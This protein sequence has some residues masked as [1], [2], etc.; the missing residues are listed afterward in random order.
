MLSPALRTVKTHYS[1]F[2]KHIM[3]LLQYR[4]L[5]V[6]LFLA[7]F[8][9]TLMPLGYVPKKTNFHITIFDKCSA[10]QEFSKQQYTVWRVG[11]TQ[12]KIILNWLANV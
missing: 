7:C 4:L 6:C 10:K 12:Q 5:F 11:N 2:F 3:C 1:L 8:E 9:L